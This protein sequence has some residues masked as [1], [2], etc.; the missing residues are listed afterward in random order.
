MTPQGRKSSSN[1]LQPPV[2]RLYYPSDFYPPRP[3]LS[4]ASKQRRSAF[5]LRRYG[6]FYVNIL[7]YAFQK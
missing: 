7:T 3:E 2:P 1:F 6:I 4:L 5:Q